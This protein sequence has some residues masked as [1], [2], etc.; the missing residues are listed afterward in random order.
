LQKGYTAVE[1]KYGD[2]LISTN[3]AAFMAVKAK[4]LEA[5]EPMFKHI[6][7]NWDEDVWITE[8]WFKQNRDYADLMAPM[9][10][11]VRI[12]RKDAGDNLKSAGGQGYHDEVEARLMRFERPCVTAQN[13]ASSKFQLFVEIGKDGTMTK[14]DVETAD[15][16]AM[17]HCIVD[18]LYPS[19]LKKETLFPTP[20]KAPY[21]VVVDIDPAALK[22]ASR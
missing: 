8:E 3:Y 4:E 6:G 14:L 5:A 12:F 19:Y 9:L 1:K 17:A 21:A 16:N 13:I 18:G 15:V 10:A 11:K 2:S 7:D 20:S 22:T